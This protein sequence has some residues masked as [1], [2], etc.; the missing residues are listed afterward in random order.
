MIAHNLPHHSTTFVGRKTERAEIV[1]R[2]CD[3]QC[4]LL[5]LVGPGGIGK[6]RLATQICSD[7][8]ESK[9]PNRHLFQDGVYFVSLQALI[10]SDFN[11][12]VIGDSLNLQFTPDSDP[13]AQLLRYLRPKY[14]L[15]VLDN[16]EHLLDGVGLI[17]RLLEAAPHVKVLMTSRQAL[18]IQEEWLYPLTGMRY[19]QQ[20]SAPI[21]DNYDAIQLFA[22]NAKRLDPA[23]S[24]EKEYEAVT[25]ICRHVE[26]MP[27]AIELATSW[28]RS[29]SASEIANEIENGMDILEAR[30]TNL[31][32]RHQSM[33]VMLDASWKRLT[34]NEQAVFQKLSVFRGG[35][36]REAAQA[37]TDA[38]RHIL[39]SLV[40]KSWLRHH[41]SGRYD[42]HELLRQFGE[43]QLNNQPEEAEETYKRHCSFYA[44]FLIQKW[45]ALMGDNPK[46]THSDIETELENIWAYWGWAT[47]HKQAAYIEP[48]LYSLWTF[49]DFGNR[50]QE[51]IQLFGKAANAF[52]T[53]EGTFE[54]LCGKLW[55]Y[56]GAFCQS[57]DRYPEAKTLLTKSLALLQPLGIDQD[58]AFC[59]M[60][61]GTVIYEFDGDTTRARDY[62]HMSSAIYQKLGLRYGESVALLWLG[63]TYHWA[64]E[65]QK[66][67][68]FYGQ[69]LQLAHGHNWL[70]ASVTI[71]L[72]AL[73]NKDKDHLAALEHAKEGLAGFLK[74]DTVWGIPIAY[75]VL[76]SAAC[77][78]GQYH[79]AESYLR[80]SLTSAWKY[81]FLGEIIKTFMVVVELWVAQEKNERALELLSLRMA[82]PL[83]TLD[84]TFEKK[85]TQ[86][87]GELEK[88]LP[89]DKFK[90]AWERGK[91][92]D[93]EITVQELI[94]EFTTQ[95]ALTTNN[96]ANPLTNR[97]NEIIKLV[98][99]G[100]SNKAIAKEFNLTEGTVKWHLNEI[101][102]EL[103]VAN[104]TQ[105]VAKARELNLL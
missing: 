41:S 44:N 69:T 49:Y 13:E 102:S 35:F 18:N 45:E 89:P 50:Y 7:V 28:I 38:N 48:A 61:L 40:D 9:S 95:V 54:R 67:K 83:T 16:F 79:D 103:G 63:I 33:R 70:L 60:R 4:R 29:L 77:G 42:I 86:L 1:E 76:A 57:L 27:L 66:A 87:L 11:L 21:E 20:A 55:M 14:L 81:R 96:V 2:L 75:R 104:R 62:L 17:S 24:L 65:S 43:E 52:E 84:T 74:N 85:E 94:E 10:S 37:V 80:Q 15:L 105:A 59:L 12:S 98:A 71:Q 58:H 93:F 8:I 73:A 51:A 25:R 78:L 90:L 99:T 36:T 53:P 101:Y 32:A 6:T 56:E 97:Q 34:E 92:H 72:A 82:S 22:A 47:S 39:A 91:A 5:T 68:Q 31:P 23:F 64:G 100:L 26:G 88:R 30:T 19:P 46:P 3:P